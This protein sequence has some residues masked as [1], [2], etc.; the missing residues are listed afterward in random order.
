MIGRTS[1]PVVVKCKS[2][3]YDSAGWDPTRFAAMRRPHD[4]A[5]SGDTEALRG[6][7]RE[8]LEAGAWST[9]RTS[10]E[11]ALEREETAGWGFEPSLGPERPTR[12]VRDCED[13]AR[14]R[15]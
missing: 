9:A 7:P 14:P 11:A 4:D 8:V 6:A 1:L 3:G 5:V 10:L 15:L 13:E 2:G 12:V